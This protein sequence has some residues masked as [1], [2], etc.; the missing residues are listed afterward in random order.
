MRLGTVTR[1]RLPPTAIQN[2]K[3]FSAVKL[4]KKVFIEPLT[5][6]LSPAALSVS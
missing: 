2:P 5:R 6:V 4:I 1:F 3:S